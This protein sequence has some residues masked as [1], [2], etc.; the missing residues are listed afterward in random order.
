MIFCK[1]SYQPILRCLYTETIK[2][3]GKFRCINTLNNIICNKKSES[4][5]LFT[6]IT[7]MRSFF[8]LWNDF[9][10]FFL[11]LEFRTEK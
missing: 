6:T 5:S 1:R 10:P 11:I 4:W 7:I 8:V 9:Q 2:R 3:G